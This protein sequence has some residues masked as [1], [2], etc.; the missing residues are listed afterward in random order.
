MSVGPVPVFVGLAELIEAGAHGARPL[1]LGEAELQQHLVD[2]HEHRD[3]AEEQEEPGEGQEQGDPGPE[4]E[5]EGGHRCD[6]LSRSRVSAIVGSACT[7][8]SAICA[9]WATA[10]SYLS[11]RSSPVLGITWMARSS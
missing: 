3:K 7:S 5:G 10:A 2:L 9:M 1:F 6:C 4:G 8:S 11:C